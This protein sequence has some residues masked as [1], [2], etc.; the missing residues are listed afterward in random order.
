MVL[1]APRRQLSWSLKAIIKFLQQVL[2][3]SWQLSLLFSFDLNQHQF[4]FLVHL[5]Y[6]YALL[7]SS[8]AQQSL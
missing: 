3:F 5:L 4:L 7:N 8:S 6:L 2:N 1:R